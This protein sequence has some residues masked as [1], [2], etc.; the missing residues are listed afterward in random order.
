MRIQLFP[1]L[2]HG[3]QHVRVAEGYSELTDVLNMREC[4]G[5]GDG[6]L[7]IWLHDDGLWCG[8]RLGVGSGAGWDGSVSRTGDF[9]RSVHSLPSHLSRQL[10]QDGDEVF[11]VRLPQILKYLRRDN[12]VTWELTLHYGQSLPMTTPYQGNVCLH[13]WPICE[14]NPPVTGGFPSQ[15]SQWCW[16]F[17]CLWCWPA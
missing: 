9:C 7:T 8:L 2:C 5:K 17:M 1:Q 14:G 13:F 12:E 10:G 15:I 6:E 11:G 3:L 4:S 16:A